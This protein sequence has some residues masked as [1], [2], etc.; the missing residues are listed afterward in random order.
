MPDLETYDFSNFPILDDVLDQLDSQP[1]PCERQPGEPLASYRRFQIYVT[2]PPSRTHARVAQIAGLRPNTKLIAKDSGQ[3]RWAER[4]ADADRPQN[5]F[6]ALQHA[7]RAQLLR[8]TAYIAH[9]TG[10]QDATRALAAA[11]IGDLHQDEARKHLGLLTQYQHGLLR[12]MEPRRKEKDVTPKINER[13]LQDMVLNK[14][15]VIADKLVRKEMEA[16]FGPIEWEYDPNVDGPNRQSEEEPPETELWRQQPGESD[17]HFYRFRIFLSL[18]FLQSAAQVAK[19]AGISREST[20]A[21]IAS[22]WNWHERAAAFD[23]CHAGEPLARIRLRLQLL[24]DKAFEAHLHGLLDTTRALEKAEIG[25]LDQAKARRF[26]SP[27]LRSQRSHLQS[28]W[29]QHEAIEGKTADEHRDLLLDS[30]VED[31][32][33]QMLREE[34]EDE[35]IIENLKRAYGSSDDSE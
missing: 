30:L 20:L 35:R 25:S 15:L 14:R 8:E 33:I 16:V 31:E 3:W 21:R 22:K 2:L 11:A 32:A 4:L 26:L 10:L 9:F 13:R 18:K 27:L 28:F 1:H 19:M 17:Q 29:R 23:A 24:H 6:P 34:E 5:G 12:L 7:W